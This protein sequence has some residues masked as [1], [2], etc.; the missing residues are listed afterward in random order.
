MGFGVK[1]KWAVLIIILI[2]C[3]FNQLERY[4]ISYIVSGSDILDDTATNEELYGILSGPAYLV[5]FA[6][7]SLPTGYL[8]DYVITPKWYI[9]LLLIIAHGINMTTAFAENI[10]GLLL[11]RVFFSIFSNFIDPIC[12][13]AL[14]SYFEPE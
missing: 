10:I 3:S 7:L 2:L 4:S 5:V 14:S 11:P 13:K 12:L 6:M 1:N 9:I 8:V